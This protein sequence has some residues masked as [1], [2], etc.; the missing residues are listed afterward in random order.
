MPHRTDNCAVSCAISRV[1]RKT[2][3]SLC[4]RPTP[5]VSA[6]PPKHL[7]RLNIYHLIDEATNLKFLKFGFGVFHSGVIVYG[8]E[9]S[10]G[11]SIEAQETGLFCVAP[12]NA[13][14]IPFK[15]LDLGYTDLSPEQVD[16]MLHRLETEWK[17]SDYHV[18][19]KNCNHFAA[20][21]C[22]LL[23][24][25]E[26]L[27]VPAW[28]N[29]A[30]R[31]SDKIVPMS[32]ASWAL[33]NMDDYTPPPLATTRGVHPNIGELPH[34]II[35]LQWYRSAALRR[36]PRYA[37]VP[38]SQTQPGFAPP[39][40]DAPPRTTANASTLSTAEHLQSTPPPPGKVDATTP[41]P[42]SNNTGRMPVLSHDSGTLKTNAASV[43]IAPKRLDEGFDSI[44]VPQSRGGVR[45]PDF[46]RALQ[47]QQRVGASARPLEGSSSELSSPP[48]PP[49]AEESSG[50]RGAE[51]K[52]SKETTSA[53]VGRN[54][55]AVKHL[56]LSTPPI[57]TTSSS[58]PPPAPGTTTGGDDLHYGFAHSLAGGSGT[59]EAAHREGI[60]FVPSPSVKEEAVAFTDD[61]H[62]VENDNEAP[63]PKSTPDEHPSQQHH[64][65]LHQLV[66][67]LGSENNSDATLRVNDAAGSHLSAPELHEI[68]VRELAL[69]FDS[70]MLDPN[71]MSDAFSLS[72]PALA[73]SVLNDTPQVIAA[74]GRTDDGA[75]AVLWSTGSRSLSPSAKERGAPRVV[76]LEASALEH[77]PQQ[78]NDD[79]ASPMASALAAT[80]NTV[81]D[82]E[83]L[84]LDDP[85][86]YHADTVPIH[87][88]GIPSALRG[89]V[90][91]ALDDV[92]IGGGDH[93]H[94]LTRTASFTRPSV[95]SVYSTAS[96]S[97]HSQSPAD[98]DTPCARTEDATIF[99]EA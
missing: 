54:T 6:P 44:L 63:E 75:P 81:E 62:L 53:N 10:F 32:L 31:W 70:S 96:G 85:H 65:H 66:N 56:R 90:E 48:A 46:N 22:E 33:R 20:R 15:T 21:F 64:H 17:S 71:M 73:R 12:G 86:T 98:D 79:D 2:G 88:V 99:T 8:I 87:V 55:A 5:S 9:W 83:S 47:Q 97:P 77:P 28:C 1:Q 57:T 78:A 89:S 61:V 42:A 27:E 36:A 60:P 68:S 50:N 76:L 58:P 69:P 45:M 26:T 52:Q 3:L 24:T 13:A 40:R 37:I 30:A 80:S 84:K 16:T 92:R 39:R 41:E 18:L 35:P 4:P 23:S 93:L 29:R 7:V 19:H 59:G 38:P 25:L 51:S 74:A 91:I 67:A 72:P 43:P 34:S 94:T 11:E 14:G 82:G 49:V 95:A